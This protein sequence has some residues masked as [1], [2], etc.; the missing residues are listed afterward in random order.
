MRAVRGGHFRK[1]GSHHA[2]ADVPRPTMKAP[3]RPPQLIVA[4]DSGGRWG[5]ATCTGVQN[6]GVPRSLRTALPV[7]EPA[8]LC[9]QPTGGG[10][11]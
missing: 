6:T 1:T 10:E 8:G 4:R 5:G 2:M 3:A 9:T 11:A 7:A